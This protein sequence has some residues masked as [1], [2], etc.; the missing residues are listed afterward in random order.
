MHSNEA[1]LAFAIVLLW[2]MYSAH[3][4][5]ESFPMDTSIFTGKIRKDHLRHHHPLEYEE[6]FGRH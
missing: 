1:L 5:P 6:R 2:H 3:L 4:S